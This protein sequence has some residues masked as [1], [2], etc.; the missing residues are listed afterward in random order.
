[1][2]AISLCLV[3]LSSH[4]FGPSVYSRNAN[5]AEMQIIFFFYPETKGRPLEDMDVVFHI[6]PSEEEIVDT[7][8]PTQ[9]VLPKS[10]T[11]VT[12]S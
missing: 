10:N 5:K 3:V 4:A 2:C 11:Q 8:D 12:A 9:P 7:E 6:R 1:M